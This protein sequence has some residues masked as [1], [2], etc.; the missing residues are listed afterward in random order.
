MAAYEKAMAALERDHPK[1]R[2]AA[3]FHALALLGIA[4]PNDKTYAKQKQAAEILNRVLPEEPEHPGVAHYLIHSFDYPELARAGAARRAR[5]R[6]ARAR[7]AARAAHAVAHL[8]APRAVGRVDRLES[9]V[10]GESA[11]LRR[12]R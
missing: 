3:I 12:E 5:L 8:H 4:S 7:L 11:R 1:D 2:E 10:G 6:E 9:R